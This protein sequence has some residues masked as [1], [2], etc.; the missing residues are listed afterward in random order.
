MKEL[1]LAAATKERIDAIIEK[2]RN[3]PG[4]LL[5]I[6]EEAQQLN[7]HKYLPVNVLEYISKKTG[8]PPA[9]IYGVVTFYA[10]F[11]LK[12]QGEHTITVCRGTACH[13]RGSRNLLAYLKKLLNLKEEGHHQ[14]E[15]LFL[16]TPDN[17]FTLRTVACFGQCAQAPIVEI[18]DKI[19]GRMTD[20]KLRRAIAGVGRKKKK[21]VLS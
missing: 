7:P 5:W 10:F 4:E 19:Y 15:K 20:E 6:L 14:G 18:D 2:R 17:K 3:K 21:T 8:I 9:R 1:Q 11:N 12:P 13:T 16:T